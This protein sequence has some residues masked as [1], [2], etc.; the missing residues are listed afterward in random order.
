VFHENWLGDSKVLFMAI[1]NFYPYCSYFLTNLSKSGIIHPHVI[2]FHICKFCEK[3]MLKAIFY[4][5]VNE[6]FPMFSF[7][8]FNMEQFCTGDVDRNFELL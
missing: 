4:L 5:R 7:L 6:I 8:L 3:L 1:M 2:L